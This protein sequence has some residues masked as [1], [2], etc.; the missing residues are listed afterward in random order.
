[1]SVFNALN[2]AIYNT[3]SGGTA[4]TT[5]LGGTAVYY[6]NAPDHSA[7]PYVI[8][9]FQAGGDENMT[10]IRTKD[11]ILF[12][13]AYADDPK[14]AGQLDALVDAL[15]NGITLSVTGWNNFWSSRQ[16]DFS[17]VDNMPNGEKAYM[18]GGYYRIR[19]NQS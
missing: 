9:N 13:R 19:L 3:L 17:L 2:T 10:P 1:M 4:L 14:E 12:V 18:A 16:Q 15:L 11:T 7:L 5:A 6:L 8:W